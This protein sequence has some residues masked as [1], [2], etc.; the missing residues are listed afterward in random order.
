MRT[1]IYTTYAAPKI[2]SRPRLTTFSIECLKF[3][4]LKSFGGFTLCKRRYRLYQVGL[5]RFQTQRC[6][7]TIPRYSCL[8]RFSCFTFLGLP[9]YAWKILDTSRVPDLS[10][11][12]WDPISV[13]VHCFLVL[14]STKILKPNTTHLG[15]CQYLGSRKEI[16]CYVS[17]CNDSFIFPAG[18]LSSASRTGKSKQ[19]IPTFLLISALIAQLLSNILVV[20][21]ARITC[22]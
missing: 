21:Y 11:S 12:S 22:H 8:Q 13:L 4:T 3:W 15:V 20:H 6:T 16:M 1:N 5:P 17:S 10:N 9:Y 19:S 14:P 2:V 7:F 18:P